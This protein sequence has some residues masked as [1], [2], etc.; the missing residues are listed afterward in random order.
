MTGC[1]LTER[2][3][4]TSTATTI[5]VTPAGGRCSSARTI[6]TRGWYEYRWTVLNDDSNSSL[7]ALR[8]IQAGTHGGNVGSGDV[9]E[10]DTFSIFKKRSS[11]VIISGFFIVTIIIV[12]ALMLSGGKNKRKKRR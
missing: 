2:F 7:S 1:T 5:S 12:I 4:G 3:T 8:L 9:T 10:G 6:T 11:V